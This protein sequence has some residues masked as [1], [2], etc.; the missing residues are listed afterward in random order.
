MS[1]RVC[2][3]IPTIRG[4]IWVTAATNS[5]PFQHPVWTVLPPVRFNSHLVPAVFTA[6]RDCARLYERTITM[7]F[8]ITTGIARTGFEL[9]QKY[10]PSNILLRSLRTRRGLKWGV[11]AMLLGVGYLFAAAL[12]T[13]LIK[14]G[15]TGWLNLVVLIGIWSGLKLLFFGPCILLLLARVKYLERKSAKQPAVAHV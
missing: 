9:L 4:K 13:V 15:A 8:A 6:V 14:H 11:P 7:L 12:C 3:R 10:A 5:E 2:S 1:Q